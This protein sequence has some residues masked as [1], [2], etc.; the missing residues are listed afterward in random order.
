[1]TGDGTVSSYYETTH[2]VEVWRTDVDGGGF[3]TWDYLGHY[4]WSAPLGLWLW[5]KSVDVVTLTIADRRHIDA[6]KPTGSPVVRV[7]V[8]A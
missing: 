6:A 4:G 1:M 5:E 7:E 2:E 3:E 8:E